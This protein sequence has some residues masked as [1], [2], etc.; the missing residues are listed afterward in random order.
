M[1]T[2]K[3]RPGRPKSNKPL[4]IFRGI[5]VDGSDIEDILELLPGITVSEFYRVAGKYALKQIRRR[6]LT[7][8]TLKF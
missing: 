2:I 3:R 7:F 1:E 8:L 5:Y 4:G 6:K